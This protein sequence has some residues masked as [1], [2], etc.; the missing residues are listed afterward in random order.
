M[1]NVVLALRCG[2]PLQVNVTAGCAGSSMAKIVDLGQARSVDSAA[3]HDLERIAGIIVPDSGVE[4]A[5]PAAPPHH[6]ADGVSGLE[7]ALALAEFGPNGGDAESDQRAWPRGYGH[8][9]QDGSMWM[10]IRRR[11]RPFEEPNRF[12]DILLN[13]QEEHA[14]VCSFYPMP[15]FCIY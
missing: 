8:R 5:A 7:G 1:A 10:R 4:A 2:W 13:D 12:L 14:S 15:T 9:R 3:L 6:P 11:R